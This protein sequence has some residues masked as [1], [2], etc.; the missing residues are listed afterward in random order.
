ML[1]GC[2]SS[3]QQHIFS[4]FFF[5]K[6]GGQK[7]HFLLTPSTVPNKAGKPLIYSY[8]ACSLWPLNRGCVKTSSKEVRVHCRAVER[9]WHG[10]A[11]LVW[12]AD[13]IFTLQ[14][15]QCI[16][17]QRAETDV[18]FQWRHPPEPGNSCGGMSIAWTHSGVP[19][20]AAFSQR[21]RP[22]PMGLWV[23]GWWA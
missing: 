3:K 13:F 2:F 23:G 7:A 18:R 5:Q 21:S 22:L 8:Y 20:S 9:R 11:S 6:A 4:F 12:F 1:S 10:Q 19:I 15:C 16:G 17:P 14:N